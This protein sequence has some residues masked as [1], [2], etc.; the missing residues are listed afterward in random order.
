MIRP[1]PNSSMDLSVNLARNYRF[2]DSLKRAMDISVNEGDAIHD[3][4]GKDSHP[5]VVDFAGED[6][7]ELRQE[8]TKCSLGFP[9]DDAI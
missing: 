2:L 5:R 3:R 8:D 4:F 1:K 9:H 7:A 6:A